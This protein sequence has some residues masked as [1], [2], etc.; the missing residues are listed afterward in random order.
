MRGTVAHTVRVA[1]IVWLCSD[2]SDLSVCFGVWFTR[3]CISS[4]AT[5]FAWAAQNWASG[6]LATWPGKAASSRRYPRIPPFTR[7]SF[8]APGKAGQDRQTH[9]SLLHFVPSFGFFLKAPCASVQL[10][11]PRRPGREPRHDKLVSSGPAGQSQS[12]G[13]E[14]MLFM[15]LYQ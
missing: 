3:I 6:P 9:L 10:P 4:P 11:V 8:R 14:R 12:H 5:Y 7:P 13:G 2:Q 1:L 15:P